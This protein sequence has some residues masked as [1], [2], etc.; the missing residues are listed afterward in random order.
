M[1]GDGRTVEI[2]A[3][4]AEKLREVYPQVEWDKPFTEFD[5]ARERDS[6]ESKSEQ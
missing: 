6:A 1:L 2:E 5:A 3:S 4:F